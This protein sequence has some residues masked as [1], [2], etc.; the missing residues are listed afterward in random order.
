MNEIND[1]LLS[2]SEVCTLMAHETVAMLDTAETVNTAIACRMA[3]AAFSNLQGL[4]ENGEA[5]LRWVDM[6]L[7]TTRKFVEEGVDSAHILDPNRLIGVPNAAAQVSMLWALFETATLENCGQSDRKILL[8]AART[9]AEMGGLDDLLLAAE[10]PAEAF[11]AGALQMEL[12][13]I[14]NA[15]KDVDRLNAHPP[16]M[17]PG[18]RENT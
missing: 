18:Q 13:D 11:K 10:P 3:I 12:N 2:H 16:E 17:N 6:E 4:G 15:L 14:V 9:F 8:D 5:L 1:N 7:E